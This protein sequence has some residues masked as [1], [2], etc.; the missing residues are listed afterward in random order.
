MKLNSELSSRLCQV[1]NYILIYLR[2]GCYGIWHPIIIGN[3]YTNMITGMFSSPNSF[4]YSGYY[5]LERFAKNII[6][7]Y[8]YLLSGIQVSGNKKLLIG[9]L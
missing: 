6:S 3:N 4:I 8:Y 1:K 5:I 7:T 2:V 9:I